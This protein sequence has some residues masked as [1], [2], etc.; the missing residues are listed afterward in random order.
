MKL[1]HNQPSAVSCIVFM[2][3][4]CKH[5]MMNGSFVDALDISAVVLMCFDAGAASKCLLGILC[6]C[7][8]S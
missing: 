1:H 3:T 5:V 8:L 7:S 6:Q 4:D 2:G